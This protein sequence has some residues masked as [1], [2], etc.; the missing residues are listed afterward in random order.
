MTMLDQKLGEKRRGAENSERNRG[1]ERTNEKQ[2]NT[3]RKERDLL[4]SEGV[5]KPFN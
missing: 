5:P 3:E 4:W 2:R 1:R